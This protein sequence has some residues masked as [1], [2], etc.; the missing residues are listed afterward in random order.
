MKRIRNKIQSIPVGAKSAVVY[1]ASSVFTRGLAIISV[2]IFTRLMT[3]EQIGVV[4]IYNSWYSLISAFATLSLT[5]GGFAVA[6]KEYSD[7]RDE[8]ESS[9][10]TLTSIVAFIIALVYAITPIFWQKTLGLPNSLIVLMLIGFLF[11]PARD[12]W[13]SRQRY[14]YK[15][16]LAGAVSIITAI[17][18]TLA[19]IIAVVYMSNQNLKETALG[20]LFANYVIIYSVAAVIWLYILIRGK[21][22]YCKEYWKMSL[23]ISIPLIGYNIAGQVLNVSDRMMIG[24]LVNNSAV[25]IYGTLYTVSSLSLLVWQAINASFVPYLFQ[26]IEKKDH[27]IKKISNMLLEAYAV[28]AVL[29]TSFAPE[30]VKIL[31][32]KE[33][34][35]AI[36]IM[37]SIA[38]GVFFTSYANLYSNVA[39]Y[40]K[41]TKYVM[42]PAIIA[43]GIN[44][45]LNYVFIKLFGYMAAAYTTLFSYIV[46]AALQA[47]WSKKVCRENDNVISNIYDNKKLVILAVVTTGVSL[48]AIPLYSNTII[49]YIFILGEIIVTI[50]IVNRILKSEMIKDKR[51]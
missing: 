7:K 42:Y 46:L 29:L 26:N 24:R 31:A 4:N 34:Y 40:Y 39:V 41:K 33:Y 3:T 6:M 19:S 35:E 45:L 22:W 44:L 27:N 10:L 13:L 49:R 48:L 5:S 9:I 17:M 18:A 8:Y 30:I 50:I 43:A 28:I 12:F 51:K 11:T 21:K 25:G 36:Y 38:A 32:T 20:R 23:A 1:T 15:Y 2:P 16:K 37:P 47:I 14:E